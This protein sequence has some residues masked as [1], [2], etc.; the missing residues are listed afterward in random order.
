[1]KR[2]FTAP[3]LTLTQMLSLSRFITCFGFLVSA[4]GVVYLLSFLRPLPSAATSDER[5]VH[6]FHVWMAWS[7]LMSGLF[8]L[9]MGSLQLAGCQWLDRRVRNGCSRTQHGTD[10]SNE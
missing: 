5:V 6:V 1:M 2:R 7:V 9:G 8:F 4:V 3:G 10:R